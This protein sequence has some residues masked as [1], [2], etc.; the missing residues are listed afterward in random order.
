MP[1]GAL[2]KPLEDIIWNT[3]QLFY[4]WTSDYGWSIILLTVAMRV[5]L[6]P[7]T[8]KSTKSTY[9]M[10]RI[11]PKLK[12]L[13]QKYKNNKEK[14][15]EETLKFYQENKV[16]PFGGCLPLLLQMP[17]L[18]ALFR[19]LSGTGKNPGPF[20][21]HIA[22]L[23]EA[24]QEA[25]RRFWIVLPDLTKSPGAIYGAEGLVAALPYLAFVVLFAL[26]VYLPQRMMTKE[27]QQQQIGLYMA[28]MFLFFGWS[29]PAGVLLYWVTSSILQVAQQWA[30]MRVY[31]R[32][33]GAKT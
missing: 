6:L 9:E 1:M 8:I 32:T 14:L 27:K 33:E 28:A 13:Q 26:S 15:Q 30:M 5:I 17:V 24:A 7:L 10:Q 16:N 12:E 23:P 25:A 31:A 3:L 20:L 21:R 19:V 22:G 18:F 2:L 4:A 29:S 11:Q